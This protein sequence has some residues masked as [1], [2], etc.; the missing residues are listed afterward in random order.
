MSTS[1]RRT[2]T[3]RE[4]AALASAVRIRIIRLTVAEPLTNREIAERLDRDPA[5]TLHHVRKLV[6]AGFLEALPARRGARGAREIPYRGTGLSWALEMDR[7]GGTVNQPVLEAFLAEIAETGVEHMR[8]T[9]LS[10]RLGPA[11]HAEFESRLQDLIDEFAAR[12][13]E[14]DGR[15]VGLFFARYPAP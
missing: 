9:R 15:G 5:T 7:Y 13:R 11:Q 1:K 8:F 3:E 10:L 12:P 4:A 2:A 14:P 6:D